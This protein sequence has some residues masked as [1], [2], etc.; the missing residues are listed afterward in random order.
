MGKHCGNCG[1][2]VSQDFYR[3]FSYEGELEA[4]PNCTK[5]RSRLAIQAAGDDRAGT[6]TR[7]E[8]L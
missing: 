2:H 4:C 7:G 1:E 8:R 6:R 3:V 5:V